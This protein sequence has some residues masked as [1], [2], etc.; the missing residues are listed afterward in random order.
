MAGINNNNNGRRRRSM[1]VLA[2]EAQPHDVG[3]VYDHIDDIL[4]QTCGLGDRENQLLLYDG[5]D[6]GHHS[7]CLHP[8]LFHVPYDPWPLLLYSDEGES[9]SKGRKEKIYY[10]YAIFPRESTTFSAFTL[11]VKR[12]YRHSPQKQMDGDY[13]ILIPQLLLC[14]Y[15]YCYGH[16]HIISRGENLP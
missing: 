1:R 12:L 7:F 2:E 15:V 5:R 14:S 16:N 6:H 3:A 11:L 8:I 9:N 13:C 10:Q 4:C